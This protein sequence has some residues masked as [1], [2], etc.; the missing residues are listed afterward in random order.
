MKDIT[1]ALG[2]GGARGNAHIGVLRR[3][4]E[5]GYRIAAVAGTS[6][7]GLVAAFYAT[8]YS[9]DEIEEIFGAI[10]QTKLYVLGLHTSPGLLGLDKVRRWLDDLLGEQ[11]FSSTRIPCALTAADLNCNCEVTLR[12]GRLQD[13]ILASIAVPGIFPP[14][15]MDNGHDLVDGGVLNPVPV[16]LAQMLRPDLPVVA[17]ALSPELAPAESYQALVSLPSVIPESIIRRITRLNVAQAMNIFLHSVD[18]S[19]R[20]ITELRLK[21]EPPDVLIRPAVDE[22]G[23]LDQVDVREVALLGEQAIEGAL[24]ELERAVGWSRRLRRQLFGRN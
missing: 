22:I 5:E 6:F 20:M 16:S 1:V 19:N 3:L 7:G 18:V 17:V 15:R 9:P 2:G 24:P 12:T 11:K 23:L 13:A 8:G 14:F 21:I 4:E 10:D